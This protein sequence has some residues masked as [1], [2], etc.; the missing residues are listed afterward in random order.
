M[1]VRSLRYIIDPVS[2]CPP[3]LLTPTG[4]PVDQIHMDLDDVAR[5]AWN[6]ILQ[7]APG[8]SS[9]FA[10]FEDLLEPGVALVW[11]GSGPGR[12]TEMRRSFS[13]LFGRFFARAYLQLNHGFVWFTAIDGNNFSLSPNWRVRRK[14][15][16]KT[17][18][19]D[20]I[21]VRPGEL[22]IGEA[23]GTHQK[24]NCTRGGRPGPIKTADGQIKGVVVEK[25]TGANRLTGWTKKSVK[26]WAVMSRWGTADPAR[27]PFMYVLDPKTAGDPLDPDETEELS[28][29]VSRKSIEQTALGLR[30]LLEKG[31]EIVPAPRNRVTIVGDDEKRAF[32][33]AIVSPFG[34]LDV[35]LDQAIELAARIPNPNAVRFVGLDEEVLTAYLEGR[36]IKPANRRKLNDDTVVGPDGLVVAPVTEAKV[37]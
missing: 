20:W 17:N 8:S 24:G 5:S 27:D 9:L 19:P 7:T 34:I 12:G 21:C 23:K 6:E 13:G 35:G 18:M 22:A 26:G 11:S 25:R 16:L 3:G 10:F 2:A 28:Q 29:A 4:K 31:T 36:E 1:S 30:L 32:A 33:G 15:G 14:S 37:L